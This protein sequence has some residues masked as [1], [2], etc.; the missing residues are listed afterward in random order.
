[1]SLKSANKIEANVYE[2]E[3]EIEGAKFKETT[4]KVFNQKKNSINVP[5]FRKGKAPLSLIEKTYGKDVF[6]DDAIEML[7]P[8]LIE[9]AYEAGNI[10][11]VDNPYDFDI[12]EIGDEGVLFT[13]KVTVKPDIQ[14]LIY[15][16]LQGEKGEVE[17]SQEEVEAEIDKLRDRNSRTIVVEDRPA[18]DGDMTVIDFEGFVDGLAFEGGKGENH[19]LTLG[20]GSFIPGFEEQII[21]RAIDEEFDV[22][23][24]FPE[25]Y[26]PELAGKVAV[27]K[28]KLHEIKV[29][30]LPEAD[31]EFAKDIGEYDTAEEMKKG[32]EEDIR[33]QKTEA[34]EKAFE[35]QILTAL[36]D[37]AMAD[38]P[39]VM[40]TKKAKE[41]TDNFSQRLSQQGADLDTYLMYVGSDREAFD[42]QMLEDARKQVTLR[43]ALEKIGEL[44]GLT[45]SEEDFER[46]YQKFAETYSIEVEKIKSMI[47]EDTLREDI[48]SEKAVRFVMANAVVV[49]PFVM[50]EEAAVETAEDA[51]KSE[52]KPAAKKKN[53]AKKKPAAKKKT[54]T[55]D[56]KEESK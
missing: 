20:S 42:A 14:L 40:I 25:E 39:E 36:T 51:K 7:F 37:H 2:L 43:L 6:Y 46:E 47:P 33:K 50:D 16:G 48:I 11:A 3:I 35:E 44:E 54:D 13:V 38:I 24:T 1:M 17:V 12:K 18:Q 41:N 31:D 56:T 27:F 10:D 53:V 26:A 45:A 52:K 28:V 23:V 8:E 15:K 19:N 34:A 9:Q 49:A 4:Q 5:G 32:I 55:K 29:K 21:G 22:N 30:E